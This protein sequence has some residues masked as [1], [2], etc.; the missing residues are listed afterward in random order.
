MSDRRQN[1]LHTVAAVRG[2]GLFG[3][4]DAT[5][6]LVP[7]PEYHG[8]VFQRVDLADAV[9][10]PARIEY[11]VPRP[12]RTVLCRWGVCVEVVEHVL[13]ALAGLQVDNC[14]VRIDAPE[15]PNG[16][17]SARPF[18]EALLDA[19]IVPQSAPVHRIAVP[20]CVCIGTD[21]G[22]IT[23]RP[24]DGNYRIGYE[25][26]YGDLPPGRQSLELEITPETFLREIA[27]ARTFVLESE[28]AALRAAGMGLQ[29]TAR[30]LV[31]L[32]ADG[33][34][35]DN[36]LRAPDECVRHKLLDCIGDLALAGGDWCG[37]FHSVRSG[38]AQNHEIVRQV[39][40]SR[41]RR[42]A[43]AA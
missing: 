1:S 32:G 37:E 30:D 10:V 42:I 29:T 18:V 43:Q 27:F 12:R 6:E 4:A 35:V 31:V 14:L 26:D 15:T 41:A 22:G 34:P 25:L 21:R 11:V 40:A 24:A 19:G 17:G 39:L 23:A 3:G 7:A 9:R 20:R 33:R 16:D 2:R 8:I 38:H 28:I 36:T 13:A 5:L